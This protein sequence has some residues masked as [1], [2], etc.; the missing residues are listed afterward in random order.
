MITSDPNLD[1]LWSSEPSTL[2]SKAGIVTCT[3]NQLLKAVLPVEVVVAEAWS[4]DLVELCALI[5]SFTPMGCSADVLD[6]VMTDMY[7]A[8]R[9]CMNPHHD[10]LNKA[11]EM[12]SQMLSWLRD[13]TKDGHGSFS[14]HTAYETGR[15]T[16]KATS[17][18]LVTAYGVFMALHCVPAETSPVL[19]KQ[20][21]TN[22][23]GE[24]RGNRSVKVHQSIL[25]RLESLE[26][27]DLHRAFDFQ[28]HVEQRKHCRRRP[29]MSMVVLVE[30]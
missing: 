26:K 20:S 10:K 25:N 7:V 11:N 6:N 2:I 9:L 17:L 13:I 15:T 22:V 1:V 18:I 8:C 4:T 23:L 24:L 27:G 30:V 29:L 12:L 3:P 19:R 14:D 16:T 5:D 28:Q 21:A